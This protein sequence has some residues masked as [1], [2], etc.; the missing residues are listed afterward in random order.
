MNEN[1]EHGADSG[2]GAMHLRKLE[3]KDAPL[4]L[5]WMHDPGVVEKL[6]GCFLTKTL[7]DAEAFISFS[8]RD[9]NNLHLA[10]CSEEDE[11]MGTVSLKGLDRQNKSAEFAITVRKYAMAKGYA[12]FGMEEIIRKGFGEMGL[13]SIYWC[14]SGENQRAIRFYQKH[15]F[16]ETEDVPQSILEGYDSSQPLKWYRVQAGQMNQITDENAGRKKEN[17]KRDRD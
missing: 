16:Q 17:R 15:H 4:M 13:Q 2:C 9:Q 12:W 7:A 6:R 3:I 10:I 11:Y 1:R 14:V 5:E 8:R